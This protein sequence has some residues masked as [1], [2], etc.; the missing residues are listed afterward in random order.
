MIVKQKQALMQQLLTGK[1]RV[2]VNDDRSPAQV[3]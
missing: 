3:G 2:K 1:S